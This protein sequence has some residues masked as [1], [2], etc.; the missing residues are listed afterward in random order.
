MKIQWKQTG[1]DPNDL[2]AK[3]GKDVLRVERMSEDYTWWAV[4]I[5]DNHFDVHHSKKKRPRTIDEAKTQ[6]E[7]KYKEVK[8][9]K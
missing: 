1:N 6:C 4:W 9:S 7:E 5:G 8:S 2:I 3:V